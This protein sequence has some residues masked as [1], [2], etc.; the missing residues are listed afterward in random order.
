LN[1]RQDTAPSV[2]PGDGNFV[3]RERE[4]RLLG[5]LLDRSV[6]G[7]GQAVVVTG[8]AGMG[9]TRTAMEVA[10][11]A[12]SRG[13]A[14]R[15]GR[16]LEEPGAPPHWPWRQLIRA[17]LQAM[18]D[19]S[20]R[21]FGDDQLANVVTIAPELRA[22]R[23]LA[24]RATHGTTPAIDEATQ[25]F[26]V[27]DAVAAFWAGAA[28][29]QPCL[30]VL[31]DMHRA[32]AASLKLLEFLVAQLAQVRLMVLAT[33]RDDEADFTPPLVDT[34]AELARAP[35]FRRLQLA[36]LSSDETLRF[37]SGAGITDEALRE[38]I[39]AHTEGHPLFMVETVR[40]LI[41][42][43]RPVPS[44]SVLSLRG[45]PDGVRD[46]I[47]RRIAALRPST[48]RALTTAACIGRVFDLPLLVALELDRSEAALLEDLH[49]AAGS[50][51][52]E[53]LDRAAGWR[54]CHALVRESLYERMA[55][56]Q[57]AR[58]HQRIGALLEQRSEADA[59]RRLGQ[60]AYHFHEAGAEGSLDK[61]LHY[62]RLAAEHAAS[63][64][65]HEHAALL[66]RQALALHVALGLA[67][68]A[69]HAELW[70]RLGQVEVAVGNGRTAAAA[71]GQAAALARAQD[72]DEA[73]ALAA[74]GYERACVIAADPV[75]PAV[76]LLGQALPGDNLGPAL[77][78]QLQSSLCRALLYSD[79]AAEA[80]QCYEQAVALARQQGDPA[81]LY[82]ALSAFA[83]AVFVPALLPAALQGSIEAWQVLERA[84]RLADAL[85][86]NN[87]Y[88][89]VGLLRAGRT[90][91]LNRLLEAM[92]PLARRARSPYHEAVVQCMAAQVALSRGEFETAEAL[93]RQAHA[94]GRRVGAPQADS[95]LGLQMFC[96]R[97]EQGQLA[98]VMPL[99]QQ[100][101]DSEAQE[102]FWRP[103]LALLQAELGQTEA[104]RASYERLHWQD[105][106][107][108]RGDASTQTLLAFAAECCVHLDD[109]AGAARLLDLLSPLA[110]SQLVAD[111]AGPYLGSADRLLGMLATVCR[112]WNLAQRHFE[113]ALPADQACGAR[114]W[115]A[116]G[117]Y[118]YAL[119]LVRR[120]EATDRGRAREL[121]QAARHD[122][123][124]LGM[125]TLCQRIDA[126]CATI[127]AHVPAFPCGLTSREVEVLRLVAIGRNNRDIAA[128]LAISANTVANHMRSIF[129]KTYTANRT[130]AAAFAQKHGMTQG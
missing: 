115:L 112:R 16:C 46:V 87:A 24:S 52:I 28:A 93:A 42:A 113:A 63:A 100:M 17:Q 27:H 2:V 95:A 18:S 110:G 83:S 72:L 8:A 74:I 71:F 107:R 86:A 121:L 57:R 9:K 21:A 7:Q 62:A 130:E 109:A 64:L 126:L 111:L 108:L 84:G 14:V 36:G 30:L 15:W 122:T 103:G 88:L 37:V 3:G 59:G 38:A 85:P 13:M 44:G 114:V 26:A 99:L 68:T 119:M 91:D 89:L 10:V 65:A 67:D 129:E 1:E 34:L 73:F 23:H 96:I 77:Q 29:K 54:F 12:G 78:L 105:T 76:R 61:A 94:A 19:G 120:N 82:V 117:R 31:E 39:H 45:V 51:L 123:Q 81:S 49:E 50:R 124:A 66:Y 33:C 22:R 79:R 125:A 41:Q 4:L 35:H 32:D 90:A 48:A 6:A 101:Q 11:L 55:P 47:A 56:T 53:P 20:L 118:R 128:V 43:G 92:L 80:A 98:E 70:L 102:S 127:G 69:Q 116:H 5:H 75:E 60:L 25:R 106:P 104:C 40:L 58:L 97:R